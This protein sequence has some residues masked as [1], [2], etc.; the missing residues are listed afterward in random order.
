MNRQMAVSSQPSD[1]AFVAE[2]WLW[3]GVAARQ[4]VHAGGRAVAVRRGSDLTHIFQDHLGSPAL[5]T[6]AAGD[7]VASH[8]YEPYV[9]MRG[10]ECTLLIDRSFCGAPRRVYPEWARARPLSADWACTIT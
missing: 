9:T 10:M 8:R 1:I 5:K 4:D 6:D 2:K 7:G 3:K